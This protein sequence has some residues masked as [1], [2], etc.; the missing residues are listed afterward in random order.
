MSFE[1]MDFP[2]PKNS[3]LK[4]EFPFPKIENEDLK[5]TDKTQGIVY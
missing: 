5:R 4:P 3:A 2:N 1:R